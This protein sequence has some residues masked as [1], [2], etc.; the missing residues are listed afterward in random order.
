MIEYRFDE[1]ILEKAS[2]FSVDDLN[3][4][5]N[6]YVKDQKFNEEVERITEIDQNLTEK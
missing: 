3:K 4:Q 5:L 6:D 1:V 2:K